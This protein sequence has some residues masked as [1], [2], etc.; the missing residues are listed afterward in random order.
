MYFFSFLAAFLL[1]RRLRK[2]MLLTEMGFKWDK[3]L[4]TASWVSLGL[5]I[6]ASA[7]LKET[8]QD[9]LGIL[10]LTGILAYINREPDF[11]PIKSLVQAFYPYVLI[12][13]FSLLLEL[14]FP[15][16]HRK[17]EDLIGM[18]AL[19]G[20]VYFFAA[21][22]NFNKGQK[23][24]ESERQKRLVEE[25]QRRI[26]EAH[27]SE[28]E[29][30]VA[31]RTAEL[32]NQ[33]EELLQTVE[34][35]KATQAQLIQQEKLASLGELTA[36]IAH[37]IQNPLNFVN[38]FAEVSAELLEELE[39]ELRKG[40]IEEA[41]AI[42]G[43][44]RQNLQKIGHHGKRADSIVK[45]MLQHS[46]VSNGQKELTDINSLADEYLRL[47]YHGLRAKDK[48][49]NAGLVTDFASDLEKLEVVPQDLG[50]V[51]LNLFN[52]AF[53]SVQQK[54]KTSEPGFKPQV[55]VSTKRIGDE[56]EIR[57]K[58]NGSGIPENIRHKILQPFFTTKP[59]GQGTGLGLS[60]SHDIIAK[61][62]GGTL[63]IETKE[64]Q[65]AEF[66]IRIPSK[67]EKEVLI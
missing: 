25:E 53:Y 27:K 54:Q 26:I 30:L 21:W 46:R 47:S 13:F 33:K 37:E 29:V 15:D 60:L 58:D 36:G 18:G 34:E 49:F 51:L 17:W 8:L 61:G 20:F 28:L 1:L 23:A 45:G 32:T 38:N 5:F 42:A 6:V 7:T 41:V 22:V 63:A 57:V 66:I 16:F 59:T 55:T 2:S 31:Q 43:D 64:G 65:F 12:C 40:D 35:L 52:N 19:A 9:W 10:Y 4:N 44:V 14:L 3:P 50:R 39:E 11:K 24:L 62:H 48:T 56:V 67:K